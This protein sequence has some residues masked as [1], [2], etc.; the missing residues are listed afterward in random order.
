MRCGGDSKPKIS[1]QEYALHPTEI[2]VFPY[3]INF[4]INVLIVEVSLL[5]VA[6][7]L[8]F[9]VSLSIIPKTHTAFP[10]LLCVKLLSSTEH[11]LFSF[12]STNN[13]D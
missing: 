11:F 7:N 4:F 2:I 13:S 1:I 5:K 6:S 9:L 12:S 3:P 8:N 10:D